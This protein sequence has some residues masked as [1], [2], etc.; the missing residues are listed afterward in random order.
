MRQA[1]HGGD[2]GLC[3]VRWRDGLGGD[4]AAGRYVAAPEPSVVGKGLECVQAGLDRQKK[5]VSASKVVVS[6]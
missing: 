2:A 4:R 6:L 5:V 1:G 3:A